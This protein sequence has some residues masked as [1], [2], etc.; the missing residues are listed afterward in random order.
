M[1]YI[2][3]GAN[4]KEYG[5]IDLSTLIEWVRQGR[6][7][8][9]TKVRNVTNGMLLNAT[10]MPELNGMFLANQAMQATVISSGY[11]N[12]RTMPNQQADHWEDYKFVITMSVLGMLLSLAIGY[13]AVIFNIFALKRAWEATRDQKPMA[14]LGFSLALLSMLAAIVIPFLM[15]YWLQNLISPFDGHK[16]KIGGQTTDDK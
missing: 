11:L 7:S 13:F 16:S 9:D 10:H 3:R 8:P 4:G 5:P 2:V 15:G 1:Q 12:S 14:G 6:V